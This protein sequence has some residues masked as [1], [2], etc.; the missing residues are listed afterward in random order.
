MRIFIYLVV[1]IFAFLTTALAQDSE[2]LDGVVAPS[3]NK[4]KG[5]QFEAKG[6]KGFS[7]SGATTDSNYEVSA[8]YVVGQTWQ[9][10][11]T[12]GRLN[13]S[14]S[15]SGGDLK[16]WQYVEEGTKLNS[17]YKM[18]EIRKLFFDPYSER[19]VQGFF[20][21]AGYGLMDTKVEYN[22]NRYK[23]YN[24][25]ICLIGPCEKA[26]EESDLGSANVQI[27]FARLGA[28]FSYEI[29]SPRSLGVI[30]L[31][32]AVGYNEY[33]NKDSVVLSGENHKGSYDF[34]ELDKIIAQIAFGVMF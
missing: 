20:T 16:E 28:G 30:L 34:K 32:A 24:G 6:M 26:V 13:K 21:S 14:K 22:Y 25:F 17:S 23:P 4:T 15:Q 3:K 33:F 11:I 7:G 8:G 31:S 29:K 12:L 9:L 10:Q 19:R 18:L 27:P 2:S 5:L 1:S